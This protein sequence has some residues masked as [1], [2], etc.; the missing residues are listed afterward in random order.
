VGKGED[1][2]HELE[3]LELDPEFE[4]WFEADRTAESAPPGVVEWF[5]Q[6]AADLEV[7]LRE[8]EPAEPTWTWWPPDQ[9]VGFWMRRMAQETAVHRWD[10]Q[11]AFGREQPIDAEL[12]RDGIDE[13]LGIYQPQ[14]CHPKATLQGTGESYHFHRTDG[15]GEWLVRFENGDMKVSHE[16]AKADVAIRGSASDLVLFLWHRI[17]AARLEVLGDAS[18]V[19]RYFE[20]VPPD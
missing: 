20:L 18:L 2:V 1:V 14:W 13:A 16:H 11:Q 19:D 15:E 9:T 8:A 17:P 3:D 4:R 7:T 6:C 12:A 5:T 10:V